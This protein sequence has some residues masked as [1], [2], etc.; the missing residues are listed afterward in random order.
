MEENKRLEARNS[1][2]RETSRFKSRLLERGGREAVTVLESRLV[3]P[4]KEEACDRRYSSLRSH[5]SRRHAS[6]WVASSL[7]PLVAA[8]AAP[9]CFDCAPG[10]RGAQGG[11]PRD[12]E[13]REW[14]CPALQPGVCSGTT[15]PADPPW[16]LGGYSPHHTAWS[17]FVCHSL[18]TRRFDVVENWLWG[19]GRKWRGS[20]N[21][22]LTP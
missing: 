17:L 20:G 6:L 10:A 4:R 3:G 5:R 13:P 2:S 18:R 21:R 16:P 8:A 12:R 1:G 11:E 15:I 7:P 9:R 14:S 22:F 19:R